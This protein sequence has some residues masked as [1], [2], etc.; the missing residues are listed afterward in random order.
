MAVVS[1]TGLLERPAL[2]LFGGIGLTTAGPEIAV[3]WGMLKRS[4]YW[5][6]HCSL[7]VLVFLS[8]CA[9]PGDSLSRIIDRGELRLVTRN[10][11]V[12]YY[13]E[14]GE[15]RGF[16]YELASLVAEDLGV[17]LQ[18]S[19][20]FTLDALFRA[21]RRDEADIAGAGLTLTRQRHNDF[22]ASPAYH[23]Q[24]PQVI[25]RVGRPRPG[26]PG[27]LAGLKIA[28]LAGSSHIELMQNL[29]RWT[30]IPL[31]WE[32]IR[33]TDVV[34]ILERV[35]RGDADVAIVDSVEFQIQKNL[36]PRLDVAFDLAPEQKVVW[37]LTSHGDSG[38]LED[39]LA[40][41][42]ARLES[43]GTLEHLRQAYFSH[44]ESLN[45]V[46]SQTF[47][48]NLRNDLPTYRPNIE[49]VAREHQLDWALLAA[50][51]YQESH[52]DPDAVS[53][54]GVRG[55]M[56]LTRPTAEE[57]G[58]EDREDLMQS[59][60]GGA[61]YFKDLLRRLPDGIEEPDRTWMA[62]AAYNIGMGHLEDGRV[63]TQR[64]GGDPDLW[65]DVMQHLPKLEHS[66]H[67]RTVRHGYARGREAVRYVQNI[68]HYHNVL[69]WR[70]IAENRPSP[71]LAV[72][73]L[74]P[75]EI[76]RVGLMGL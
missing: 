39:Y 18:V 10:G 32:A 17:S 34:D 23:R 70:F 36:L 72:E 58:I 26:Q 55:M 63:I 21:L 4:R 25:Y 45:R 12:T 31:D 43:D 73:P 61:R 41:F 53:Y 47:I 69:Q 71:P 59:L 3:H 35:E 67:Y 7:A 14:R 29:R 57:L 50:I 46:G 48:A 51:S 28:V 56:M 74:V 24:R 38:A 37:Y 1:R 33:G 42:L 75:E 62:L 6:L 52:W 16:E 40:D 44:V 27:D 49:Q 20:A 68:R 66:E 19:T 22:P 5:R 2:Y 9:E 65:A 13:M 30:G 76:R 11:P 64:H 60:R 8:A 15:P 54:T